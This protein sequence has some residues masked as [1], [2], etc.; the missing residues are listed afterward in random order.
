ML[1]ANGKI[2]LFLQNSYILEFNLRG[3]IQTID[4]LPTKIN[5]NA[6]FLNESLIFVDKKNKVSVIN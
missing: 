1:P 3:E 4:K 2:I 6:I 5:S